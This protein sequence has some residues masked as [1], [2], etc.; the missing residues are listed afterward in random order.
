[1]A[2]TKSFRVKSSKFVF[3]K[4]GNNSDIK[5][6]AS[7]SEM[8]DDQIEWDKIKSRMYAE[9]KGSPEEA[10]TLTEKFNYLA[11]NLDSLHSEEKTL[12]LELFGLLNE[13]IEDKKTGVTF[14]ERFEKLLIAIFNT[15]EDK[16]ESFIVSNDKGESFDLGT[17]IIR[18]GSFQTGRE[19]ASNAGFYLD[20]ISGKKITNKNFGEELKELVNK[21]AYDQMEKMVIQVQNSI[22]DEK[23]GLWNTRIFVRDVK[24]QGKVDISTDGKIS[25]IAREELSGEFQT[26]AQLLSH[27]TFSL[28]SYLNSTMAAKKGG[29]VS[30]GETAF[31]KALSS[32]YQYATGSQNFPD[33]CTFVFSSKNSRKKDVKRFVNW[34]RF[35]YELTGVGQQSE[36]NGL[37]Q[38]GRLVDYLVVLNRT[39]KQ[40][41]FHH[42]SEFFKN[43]PNE[44]LEH[45]YDGGHIRKGNFVFFQN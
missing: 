26:L 32:F 17:K 1:M 28:K 38:N 3:D 10:A 37:I 24:R 27:R 42:T 33:T 14:E 21:T 34:A 39:T 13:Y 22:Q 19:T 23:S 45:I 44:G 15:G 16:E 25:L 36:I 30:L 40:I 29:G 11:Y 2:Y 12:L 18:R 6:Y 31:F 9:I 7:A 41:D 5:I 8:W 35:I 20:I 4:P 43:M